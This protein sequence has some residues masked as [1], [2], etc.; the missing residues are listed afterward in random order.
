MV[1]IATTAIIV[2]VLYFAYYFSVGKLHRKDR[3]E[4]LEMYSTTNLLSAIRYELEQRQFRIR[5]DGVIEPSFSQIKM[6]NEAFQKFPKEL[7]RLKRES[8]TYRSKIYELV[9]DTALQEGRSEQE[10]LV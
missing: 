10:L 2:S 6:Y 3:I 5:N 9:R 1:S 4:L 8:Q 7:E